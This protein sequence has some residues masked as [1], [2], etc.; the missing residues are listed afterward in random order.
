M[1]K[2][3][4][5]QNKS[6]KPI[7][8][9]AFI[10]TNIYLDFYRSSNEARIPLLGKIKD[11][12]DRIISTYQVQME[13]LKNRQTE[14]LKSLSQIKSP[15]IQMPA[16]MGDGYIQ[17]STN[18]IKEEAKKR[19]RYLHNRVENMLNQP[20]TYDQVYQALDAVFSNPNDHVLKRNMPIRQ[21]IKRLAWKRFVLGYPPR[22]K[23]D[24]SI[25]DALN[26]EWIVHC[27]QNLQGRIYI[28]SRDGDFGCGYKNNYYL[29]DQLKQE[30]RER[31]GQKSI[32]YTHKPSD[33]L[34]ALEIKVTQ[35]ELEAEEEMISAHSQPTLND[36]MT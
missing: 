24:T 34:K 2:K 13:F 21:Q 33:V 26:W 20:N 25:G 36:P 32:V 8:A 14:L 15:E 30:F 9:W 28:V 17:S 6:T 12:S 27:A 1:A 10:D 3:K 31:I 5:V 7:Q 16:V 18:K 35:Q 29:N 22:K 4:T 23:N 19:E 11:A